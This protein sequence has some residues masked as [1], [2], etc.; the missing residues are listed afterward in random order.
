MREIEFDRDFLSCL[1]HINYPCNMHGFVHP[2]KLP[3]FKPTPS[4]LLFSLSFVVTQVL[5]V[6]GSVPLKVSAALRAAQDAACS[7]QD[8]LQREQTI[9]NVL[10]QVKSQQ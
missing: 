7:L 2:S 9:S 6:S 8:L 4:V 5:A 10:K 3:V 1:G